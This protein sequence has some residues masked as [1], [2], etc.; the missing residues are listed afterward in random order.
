MKVVMTVSWTYNCAPDE[1]AR[2]APLR[3]ALLTVLQDKI[4]EHHLM[5]TAVIERIKADKEKE[6]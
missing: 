2:I 1:Y 5:H 3:N 6:E 4:M